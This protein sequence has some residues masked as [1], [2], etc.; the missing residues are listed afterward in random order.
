VNVL[1]RWHGEKGKKKTGGKITSHRKKR[2]Y[3]LGSLAIHTTIGKKKKKFSKTKGGGIKVKAVSVQSVNV[4]DPK[5]KKMKRVK[6]LDIVKNP[7]NPHLVRRG[8]ITKGALIK[9][10]LG[11]AKVTSRPSQVGVANAVLVEENK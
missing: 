10:E 6:I 3:E 2:K 7:A 1:G 8:I 5:T 11:T 4:Y 9:T